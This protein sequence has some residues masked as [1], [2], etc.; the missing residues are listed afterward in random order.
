VAVRHA[1]VEEHNVRLQ[2]VAMLLHGAIAGCGCYYFEPPVAAEHLQQHLPVQANA[3]SDQ[4]PD[5]IG[6]RY[7]K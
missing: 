7:G 1:D 3:N 2:L 4:N 6:S 5:L